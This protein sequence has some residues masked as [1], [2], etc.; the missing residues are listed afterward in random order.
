MLSVLAPSLKLLSA[1]MVFFRM[2]LTC[3]T[4][5]GSR[6]SAGLDCEP[7]THTSLG[8]RLTDSACC[9]SERPEGRCRVGSRTRPFCTYRK[10]ERELEKL[11]D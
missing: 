7:E 11:K 3:K 1:E 2:P 10:R 9:L 4:G 8:L 5:L 6:S